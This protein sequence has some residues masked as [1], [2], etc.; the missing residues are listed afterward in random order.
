MVRNVK[1]TSALTLS[2]LLSL[3][4]LAPAVSA[5]TTDPNQQDQG[6]KVEILSAEKIV[7]KDELIERF[8]EFFP[9]RFDFVT[10]KDFHLSPGHRYPDQEQTR[11]SL[12]FHTTVEGQSV[13]GGMTFVGED[14]EIERF[15]SEPLNEAAALFPAEVSKEEAR[16]LATS[17]IEEKL[18]VEGYELDPEEM[19]YPSM[20][21]DTL[22]E[23]I[24]YSFSYVK[25]KDDVP[26]TNKRIRV[27]VL[28]NGEIVQFQVPREV[29]EKPSFPDVSKALSES[30]ITEKIKESLALDL[31]YNVFTDYE[32]G[33]TTTKLVYQSTKGYRGLDAISGEWEGSDE[34]AVKDEIEYIS[35]EALEP[36]SSDFTEEEARKRAKELVA[37]DSDEISLAI[38]SYDQRKNEF[39]K[40]VIS[41]HYMYEFKNGG[42]G[43]TLE[44]DADTGAVLQYHD[45]KR[46]VLERTGQKEETEKELSKEEAVDKAVEYLKEYSPSYLDDY[47]LPM[48]EISYQKDR[49]VYH[50]TFPRVVNGL[51]VDGDQ[52][53]VSVYGDGGLQG[54]NIRGVQVDEWPSK[55]DVISKEEALETY[56][57]NLNVDLRYVLDQESEGA[58]YDLLYFPEYTEKKAAF[59]NAKTGKWEQR[60][61]NEGADVTVSHPTAEQELNFLIQNGILK[62]EDAE[63]FDADQAVTKGQALEVIMKSLTR[64]YQGHI[65][66]DREM[67]QAFENITPDHPLYQVV[68]RA[69]Q[70]GVID[71]EKETFDVDGALTREQLAVWYVRAL[72]LDKAAAFSD[73][74][75]LDFKDVSDIDEEHVGHVALADALEILPATDEQFNP[76]DDVTYAELAVSNIRLAHEAYDKEF[77]YRY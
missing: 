14:L 3:G 39:G 59:M 35:D 34:D 22:T 46:D 8:R 30:E 7:S 63:A 58:E 68:E 52:I 31:R 23:P 56:K 53:S 54:L 12:D 72:G 6:A 4:V 40:D 20:N 16:E 5:D 38:N 26:V 70:L 45:M 27:E 33:E 75:E 9:D 66:E 21:N 77:R 65:P 69:V 48:D 29:E 13:Y 74:Y 44:F 64:F 47:A 61:G 51:L 32:A 62:V 17:F 24:R 76:D 25:T 49:N 43:T 15:H 10:E 50:I 36:V 1:R 71:G 57:E 41:I 37:V 19:L 73:I 18:D 67:P 42:S 55:E 28:G 11:Y 60:F 2:T